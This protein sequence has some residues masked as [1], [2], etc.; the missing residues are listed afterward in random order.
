MSYDYLVK[1][2]FAGNEG[3]GKS[4]LVRRIH[5]GTFANQYI[6][7]IGADFK[8]KTLDVSGKSVK[9]QMWD[10]AGMERFRTI[11]TAYF[12]GCAVAVCVV[13]VT[14]SADDPTAIMEQIN[15]NV[16]NGCIKVCFGN[17]KEPG[18]S[19]D[20][21]IG[22]QKADE[23]G[24]LWFETNCETGVGV[25]EAWAEVLGAWLQTKQEE[26]DDSHSDWN[27]SYSKKTPTDEARNAFA[28][29]DTDESGFIDEKE[30]RSALRMLGEY[31]DEDEVKACLAAV[32]TSK[33][34]KISLEEFTAWFTDESRAKGNKSLQQM[35]L[36]RMAY[37]YREMESMLEDLSWLPENSAETHQIDITVGDYVESENN[38]GVKIEVNTK[39]CVE[40]KLAYFV[41]EVESTRFPGWTTYWPK[42]A[43]Y[44]ARLMTHSDKKITVKVAIADE[45]SGLIRLS[46]APDHDVDLAE[47][48][49]GAFANAFRDHSGQATFGVTVADIVSGKVS[50]SGALSAHISVKGGAPASAYEDLKSMLVPARMLLPEDEGI[51]ALANGE[52]KATI[53]VP[54]SAIHQNLPPGMIP[55]SIEDLIQRF[56]SGAP[57]QNELKKLRM[58][59]AAMSMGLLTF[60]TLLKGVRSIAVRTPAGL[61]VEA[62][63]QGLNF[64]DL[65]DLAEKFSTVADGVP[66]MI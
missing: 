59:G 35:A 5:D 62:T 44:F 51:Q 31:L 11:T 20:A 29:L 7:T 13:D 27:F 15:S 46:V 53:V 4:S 33:D 63:I 8:C 39:K 45:K 36:L 10:T 22:K 42:M 50:P 48:K 55:P 37:H 2:V 25:S 26:K 40:S 64:T 24:Y 65:L 1:A 28:K 38:L 60:T 21:H 23:L 19:A 6:Q 16:G 61:G 57:N 14:N 32:D 66:D 34:G 18:V 17:K 12:R 47:L 43:K 58:A 3:A 49:I 52:T 56:P 41:A 54:S 9:A 30:L